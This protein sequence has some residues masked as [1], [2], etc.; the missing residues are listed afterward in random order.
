MA[1]SATR[2]TVG[3]SATLLAQGPEA[4]SGIGQAEIA[5]RVPS[6]G[7]VVYLGGGTAVATSDGFALNGGEVFSIDLDSTESLY[8]ITASGSQVVH[9]FTSSNEDTIKTAAHRE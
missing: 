4:I 1:I 9:V 7:S 6:G 5:V 2:G 8:G 3:D